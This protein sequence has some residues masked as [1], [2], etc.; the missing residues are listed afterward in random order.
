ME[1]QLNIKLKKEAGKIDSAMQKVK[2]L[3]RKLS[4]DQQ[5]KLQNDKLFE[6]IY[7]QKG[8]QGHILKRK[9]QRLRELDR[10]MEEMIKNRTS[11]KRSLAQE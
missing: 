11:Y 7:P 4:E 1:S 6:L 3:Q 10:K 9:R 2:E 5:S 8:D